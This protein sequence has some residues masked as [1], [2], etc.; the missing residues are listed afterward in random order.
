M[1]EEDK[2]INLV[3]N[4]YASHKEALDFIFENKPDR[5]AEMSDIIKNKVK[6]KGFVLG[7]SSKAYIRFLTTRMDKIIPRKATEWTNRESFL[8]E[9]EIA[10][11]RITFRAT[12]SPGDEEVRAILVEIMENVK[13]A[14]TPKGKKWIAHFIE[15]F[16]FE[17]GEMSDEEIEN[18]IDKIF[19]DKLSE[20]INNVDEEML[21]R[22]QDL[23]KLQ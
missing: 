17:F 3:K 9:F 18:F 15:G 12:I 6:Q 23:Q 5:L 21:K 8:F 22:D 16:R 2:L 13:G 19:S 14:K 20:I 1:G 10:L 11:N 4:I 7:S